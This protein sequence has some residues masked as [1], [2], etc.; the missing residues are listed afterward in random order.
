MAATGY[1]PISLYYSTTASATPTAGNLVAGELALNTT[2]EKLYFK[3]AAGTVKLLASNAASATSGTSILYGNGSGGFSNVTIGSGVS[4]AGG[5]LSATGSGG[6][7]TSVA[8]S[9]GTTGLTTSGGPITTSGTI[10]L[11]GTLATTN[12]GTG[13]T[14]FT[15]GGV[16]YAS[17][18]SA[19]ATGSALTF[20]PAGAGL[21][22][23]TGAAI[24]GTNGPSSGQSLELTYGAVAG[25]GRVMAY[26][27]TGGAE[28][29]LQLRGTPIT[30]VIGGTEQMRLTST[31]LGIG[32]SSPARKLHAYITTGPVA[33]FQ[34]SGSNAATEYVPGAIDG[35]GTIFNWVIGAQYNISNAFEI[36]PS[37]AAGGLT[38]STPAF[39]V[40]S[41]GN[42]GIGTT[43]P[44]SKLTVNG[45]IDVGSASNTVYSNTLTTYNGTTVSLV[46]TTYIAFNT[47]TAERA[48]ISATGGFSV[49]TTADPGAGAIYATG[50]ITAYYSDD[51]L[52]TRLG[53]IENALDKVDQ[54]QGFYYE[55]NKT[56]QALGY[57]VKREVGVSAQS[58]QAV[59]P[60]IVSPAPIDQQYLTV[61][62]E[63]LVPLLI[64]AVKELRAEV[65]ALKG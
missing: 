51:R 25:T 55:A 63:R 19:L 6:S 21:V 8:V 43:S 12:G 33:R 20:N 48:R 7:V 58:V 34:T 47:A 39:V 26:D 3:N 5:T 22:T 18:T 32:T 36:T 46:A 61:D 45:N 53:N 64:E 62:Y 15:S 44:I 1:T 38:F 50:N 35:S 9:G 49:G 28:T 10:T 4:F 54:L 24:Q 30:Y 40:Q 52:K 27:R 29:T 41:G 2:D 17:S 42:V 59:L 37:T 60:E 56:A 23:T 13:L 14:S 11:A 16:V 31:G 57:K 65:K